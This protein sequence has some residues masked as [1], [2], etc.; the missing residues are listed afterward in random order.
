MFFSW[1]CIEVGSETWYIW[2]LS[3]KGSVSSARKLAMP[4]EALWDSEAM[5]ERLKGIAGRKVLILLNTA[6]TSIRL[7]D[8]PF[9]FGENA[10]EY[11]FSRN[12]ILDKAWTS[13]VPEEISGSLV[14]MCRLLSVRPNRILHLDTL[15]YRMSCYFGGLFTEGSFWLI[16]P[17]K[18]GIR[19]IILNDGAALA[20]YFISNDPDFRLQ[21]LTRIWM[22]Q[23]FHPKHAVILSDDT[24]YF[25][26]WD[27][28]EEKSVEMQTPT[29]G[30]DFVQAMIESWVKSM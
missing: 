24:D 11:I 10:P 28:L 1:T 7:S 6:R 13:A 26:I 20:C 23:Q 16:L 12:T 30:Q 18:P 25:W 14:E 4:P 17:Q 3:R 29:E 19:L 21:E 9:S 5:A 8:A 27:F 15:E 22:C 2:E